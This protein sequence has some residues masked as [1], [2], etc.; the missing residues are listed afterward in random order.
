MKQLLYLALLAL[1]L[2]GCAVNRNDPE[3]VAEATVKN[4]ASQN[5]NKLSALVA[6]EFRDSFI[7]SAK[8]E[9]ALYQEI[10][11]RTP[12]AYRIEHISVDECIIHIDA[13]NGS[14]RLKKTLD[15]WS[16]TPFGI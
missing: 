7:E 1:L 5:W 11:E 13:W 14:I 9:M 12:P 2:A 6:D 15:S 3:A 8:K 10:P 16:I 4:L